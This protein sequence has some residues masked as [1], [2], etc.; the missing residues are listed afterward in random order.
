[1]G[2]E[3]MDQSTLTTVAKALLALDAEQDMLLERQLSL[4]QKQF[5]IFLRLEAITAAREKLWRNH[6]ETSN[7]A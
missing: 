7:A 3:G 4:A 5:Q 6:H 2:S 1:M